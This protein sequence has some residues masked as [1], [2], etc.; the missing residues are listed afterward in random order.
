MLALN[1]DAVVLIHDHPGQVPQQPVPSP[2]G[3]RHYREGDGPAWDALLD[4][5]FGGRHERASLCSQTRRSQDLWVPERTHF[6]V[7]RGVP[8]SVATACETEWKGK[9]A[10]AFGWVGTHPEHRR[11]GLARAVCAA[12]LLWLAKQGRSRVVVCTGPDLPGAIQL[13]LSLGFVPDTEAARAAMKKMGL[14][15]EEDGA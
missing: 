2:Y 7:L 4:T 8:V 3:L 6:A 9:P 14:V 12:C 10:G 15:P 5:A 13:Y 1:P 11:K